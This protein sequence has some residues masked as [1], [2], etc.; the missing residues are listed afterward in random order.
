MYDDLESAW[1]MRS[2]PRVAQYTWVVADPARR[3]M[4]EQAVQRFTSEVAPII[5]QLPQ[6]ESRLQRLAWS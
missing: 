1:Y 3:Q 2:V 4:A 5:D 6:G